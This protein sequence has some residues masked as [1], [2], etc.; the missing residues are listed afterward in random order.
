M[1][2]MKIT[3][4]LW[5]L[6]WWLLP[7]SSV[8]AAQEVAYHRPAANR[9]LLD[10]PARLS[11]SGVLLRE[12]LKRLRESSGVPVVFSSAFLPNQHVVRCA[13]ETVTV[14]SAL[15][16]LLARTDLQYFETRT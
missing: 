13:C 14:R 2:L 3:S 6:T 4:A 5:L 15:D 8:A 7:P 11:V 1:T 12:A 10:Q 9:S 16:S